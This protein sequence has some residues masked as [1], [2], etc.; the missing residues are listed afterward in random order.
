MIVKGG[1]DGLVELVGRRKVIKRGCD[2][3]HSEC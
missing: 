3:A 2:S 1:W